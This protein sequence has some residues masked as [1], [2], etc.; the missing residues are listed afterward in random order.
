MAWDSVGARLLF[1]LDSGRAGL[2]T[3]PA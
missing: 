3:L 1:G 2:L